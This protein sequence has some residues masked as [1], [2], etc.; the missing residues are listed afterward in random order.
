[1][2]AMQEADI[3]FGPWFRCDKVVDVPADDEHGGLTLADYL[4]VVVRHWPVGP[5]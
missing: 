1:M 5:L 2:I 4:Q 3:S